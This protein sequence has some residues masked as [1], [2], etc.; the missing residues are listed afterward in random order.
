MVKN[1]I[2]LGDAAFDATHEPIGSICL[3][4]EDMSNW[5][6]RSLQIIESAKTEKISNWA[7]EEGGVW[8]TG[9]FGTKSH[10]SDNDFENFSKRVADLFNVP[11]AHSKIIN[12]RGKGGC[13]IDIYFFPPLDKLIDKTKVSNHKCTIMSLQR[14][15]NITCPNC[16]KKT[17]IIYDSLNITLDPEK[18][19]K[20]LN[21]ELFQRECPH[22]H[23][24][25]PLDFGFLYHDM[26][27]HLKI[28]YCPAED[29]ST[30]DESDEELTAEFMMMSVKD[31]YIFRM[32][33]GIENLQEKIRIFD[34]GLNDVVIEY[35]KVFGTLDTDGDCRLTF[36]FDR[37]EDGQLIFRGVDY[38]MEEEG[39]YSFPYA[40]YLK[41]EQEVNS[42]KELK[43]PKGIAVEINRNWLV[44]QISQSQDFYQRVLHPAE[45][46]QRPGTLRL[47]PKSCI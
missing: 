20:L 28:H 4:E 2:I 35:F 37:I 16:N 44:H 7:K 15:E 29:D 10:V 41:A 39:E 9:V 11:L 14:P 27:K 19:E 43:V 42:H 30:M 8:T 6:E 22:C 46:T 5:A 36:Y 40:D 38:Q 13:S 31:S 21:G 18:K 25:F 32:V 3:S 23:E 24:S 45:Q 47:Y 26:E 17:T 34:A 33:H 1:W 12:Y